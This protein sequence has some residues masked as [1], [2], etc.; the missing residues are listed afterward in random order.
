MGFQ[1]KFN[2]EGKVYDLIPRYPEEQ[3]IDLNVLNRLCYMLRYEQQTNQKA[4]VDFQKDYEDYKGYIEQILR[5]R[6]DEIINTIYKKCFP[7]VAE[8]SSFDGEEILFQY[9]FQNEKLS[10]TD[11]N[12]Q[13]IFHFY[14]LM[15]SNFR[16]TL[17]SPYGAIL[18]GEKKMPVPLAR[19]LCEIQLTRVGELKTR[20]INGRM[21]LLM[22]DEYSKETKQMILETYSD[23]ELE[24]EMQN[25]N[26][27]YRGLSLSAALTENQKD[28]LEKNA[29]RSQS[30]PFYQEYSEASKV[31]PLNTNQHLL[32]KI[33]RTSCL[34]EDEK[35]RRGKAQVIPVHKKRL[36]TS[37]HIN[38]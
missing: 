38:G 32:L 8:L 26:R 3:E 9:L 1:Y 20:F 5:T 35:K 16:G 25:F 21:L 2:I 27:F 37:T 13:K 36:G 15:D 24:N 34:L 23:E 30:E 12:Y 7:K 18:L 22:R 33:V 4:T 6:Q 28:L 31:L 29:D 17:L 11:E 14:T 10:L 19:T